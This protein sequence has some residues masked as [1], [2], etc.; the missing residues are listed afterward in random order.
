M[1]NHDSFQ[2]SYLKLHASGELERRAER[3]LEGLHACRCCPWDCT[4]DRTRGERG[5]CKIERYARVT[6]YFPH[7]GEEDCLRGQYG[8]GTIFFSSCNLGC[9][10][11]QNY[12]ISHDVTG[13]EM[14]PDRLAECMLE[15]QEHGCHNINWVTPSHV[16]PQLLE[17]MPIAVRSGLRLPIVYNS[18]GFDAPESLQLLD[19]II[20]IYMPDFKLWSE[21]KARDYLQCPHYPQVARNALK[22]MHRQVGDLI[23]D[24]NGIAQHGLLVRHLVLPEGLD[25]SREIFHFLAH[26]IS[27]NTTINIMGQY[28]PAG[29][30]GLRRYPELNRVLSHSELQDAYRLAKKAGLHRF[31]ER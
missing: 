14:R 7:H 22:E 1:T 29:D 9:V 31:T 20:D 2:P 8:S 26:N 10:F 16:V 19:G 4:I 13:E 6:S 27:P 12:E 3:A 25:D 30:V 24:E 21:S 5:T 11:C 17:A 18:G 28:H 15:L 23:L